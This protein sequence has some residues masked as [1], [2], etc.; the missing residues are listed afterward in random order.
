MLFLLCLIQVNYK[1]IYIQS[2]FNDDT[3]I[4]G[5]SGVN[6]LKIFNSKAPYMPVASIIG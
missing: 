6:E 2:K 4:A 5:S 1:Y 3:F